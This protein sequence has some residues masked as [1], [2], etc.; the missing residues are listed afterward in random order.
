MLGNFPATLQLT[1]DGA[2]AYVVNF[3]LHGEM[4]PSSVSIVS[5]DEMVE[6]ARVQTCTMPHGSRIN[7][8]GTKQYSACMMDD[9]VVEIDTRTF[10]VSRRLSVAK[11][12]EGPVTAGHQEH[13]PRGDTTSRP[14]PRAPHPAPGASD[15]SP[16]CNRT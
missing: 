10:A 6:V 12:K 9:M 7:A 16:G 4:V 2:F 8:Q 13:A 1:P 5:T 11:G 15:T 3:N 14:A